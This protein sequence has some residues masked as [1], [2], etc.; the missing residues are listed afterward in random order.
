MV[1]QVKDPALSLLT[2]AAWVTAVAWVC[3]LA[4]VYSLYFI[5]CF[6]ELHPWHMEVPRL[7][8]KSEL[9]L[10]ALAIAMATQDPSL[11]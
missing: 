2:A 7:G 11:I 4:L 8:V 10:L 5:F 3:S 6:L 9:Q 1:Q